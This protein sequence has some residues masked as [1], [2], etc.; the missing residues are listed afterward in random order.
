MSVMASRKKNINRLKTKETT[1]VKV[2]R[3]EVNETKTAKVIVIIYYINKPLQFTKR[4]ENVSK[5]KVTAAISWK[6]VIL[7]GFFI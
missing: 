6:N 2:E 4:V 1:R 7:Y 3:P 5:E